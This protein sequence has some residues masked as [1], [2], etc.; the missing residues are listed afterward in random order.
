MSEPKAEPEAPI[1]PEQIIASK[2]N[3]LVSEYNEAIDNFSKVA[4]FKQKWN[5]VA[6]SRKER[7]EWNKNCPY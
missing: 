4:A 2:F 1:S 7:Q 5:G 3:D 6:L